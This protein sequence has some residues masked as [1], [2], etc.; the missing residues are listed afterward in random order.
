MAGDIADVALH[1]LCSRGRMWANIGHLLCA[2]NRETG[3]ENE[4][5]NCMHASDSLK[6]V[7]VRSSKRIWQRQKEHPQFH[8]A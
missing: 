3:G 6:V 8:S 5:D 2:G 7:H 1:V 4:T